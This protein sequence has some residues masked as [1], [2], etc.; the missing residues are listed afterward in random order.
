M[1]NDSLLDAATVPSIVRSSLRVWT[2]DGPDDTNWSNA[3]K[4]GLENASF[5]NILC[6]QNTE[7][8]HSKK[9]AM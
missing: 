9:V 1:H 6:C 3:L 7:I 2:R 5:F 4:S 8:R